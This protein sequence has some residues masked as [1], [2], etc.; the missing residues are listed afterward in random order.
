LPAVESVKETSLVENDRAEIGKGNTF[1]ITMPK[2][3]VKTYRITCAA[4]PA[5]VTGLAAKAVADMQVDLSW[6]GKGSHFNIYRDTQPD[7][8]PTQLNFIGQ[9][10][11]GTF[12]DQPRPNIGGWLRSCLA[13][14][15]TY[16]YRVVSVDRANNPGMP[17]AVATVTTPATE[18]ANLPP[19]AVEGVRAIL[20]SPISKDNFVNLLFRT[21]CEPDVA[22][23]EIYRGTQLIGTVNSEDIPPRSGGYGEQRTQ[24]KVKDYDH[25]TYTDK[26]VEAD[27]T[28]HYKI[29][30]VDA[31]GQKGAF[32]DEVSIRT[33]EVL[34]KTSAQSINSPAFDADK[35]VDGD[36]DPYQAWISK[37]YGGGTKVAPLDVWWAVEFLKKPVTIK[38]VKIIGDHRDVIPL[39]KNLQVQVREGDVWKTVGELKEATTK[40][41]TITFAQPVTTG[42]LR[43]FVPV[44]DLP[45]SDNALVDG[46]VR[47]CELLFIMP[48]GTEKGIE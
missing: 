14:K 22:R 19:V 20:V 30:A 32:S 11:T 44:A 39:Q 17:G 9:S 3:G 41:V 33:K 23:Y 28:Y 43:V 26:A 18:Q 12:T 13:P 47:I 42:A 4:T 24:Y 16:Y 48:D 35:A 15:T 7:C 45:K 2:F 37:Q 8:A 38:G 10:A 5:T 27:T 29:R 31:A 36:P 46:I 6:N 21:S 40:D 1:K 25:A 34:S